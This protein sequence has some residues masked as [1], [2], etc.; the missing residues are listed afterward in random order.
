MNIT[1]YIDRG[2]AVFAISGRIDGATAAEAETAIL[3]WLNSVRALVIEL[4]QVDYVSSAGLRVILKAAKAARVDTKRL[5]LA[6]LTPQVQEVFDISG[7]SS[8]LEI[9]PSGQQAVEAVLQSD[10]A[11]I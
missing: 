4:R 11:S 2:V 7:F 9:H 5:V 6:G 1:E 3:A 10:E 8:I